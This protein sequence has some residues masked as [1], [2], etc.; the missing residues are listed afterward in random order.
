MRIMDTSSYSEDIAVDCPILEVTLPGFRYSVQFNDPVINKDFTLN[1]TACDLEVQTQNCGTS[2]SGLPDGVYVIK[3]SVAPN[4]VVFVEYNHLRITK[5]LA[6]Y[7]EVLCDL[8][9]HPCQPDS[10]KAELLSEMSYIRTM[11]D[12]AVSNVE[13]CQSPAQGMQIYNYAKQRLNQKV[14]FRIS[15]KLTFFVFKHDLTN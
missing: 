2:F 15:K 3:Y 9:V 12:A 1:L 10:D 11:I 6:T 13:Y 14:D 5:A 8:D 4:N 7:N